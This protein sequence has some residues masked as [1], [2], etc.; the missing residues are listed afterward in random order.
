MASP[1]DRSSLKNWLPGV[2]G[3]ALLK[4]IITKGLPG[5]AIASVRRPIT[6]PP[7]ALVYSAITSPKLL[8]W[9]ATFCPGSTLSLS[10]TRYST[11][12]PSSPARE[13]RCF[14]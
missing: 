8:R 13:T 10:L 11:I 6:F 7:I 14:R 2:A 9:V 4:R 5:S 1:S 3:V 12:P